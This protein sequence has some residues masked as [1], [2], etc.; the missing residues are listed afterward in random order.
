MTALS[1]FDLSKV[2]AGTRVR[3]VEGWD[4]FPQCFVPA[5]T[6]ATVIEN[7]LNE[8]TSS[9][10]VLPDDLEIR[11]ALSEWDGQIELSPFF[12]GGVAHTDENGDD[13]AWQD[14]SPLEV[15]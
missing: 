13:L 7:N 12:G 10:E 9:M 8:I 3:F 4:I 6:L 2:K 5:G 11:R 14:R 1:W 15:L